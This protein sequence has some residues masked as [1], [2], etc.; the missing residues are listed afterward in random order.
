M[1]EKISVNSVRHFVEYLVDTKMTNTNNLEDHRKTFTCIVSKLLV[2][3][4]PP[5]LQNAFVLGHNYL[6]K[7]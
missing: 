6:E 1:H 7:M 3:L 2:V 5:C 4:E